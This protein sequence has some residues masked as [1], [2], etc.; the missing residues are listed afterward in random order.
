MDETTSQDVRASAQQAIETLPENS[1]WEDV[2]YRI[3]V[4]QKIEEGLADAEAERFV[5]ETDLRQQLGSFPNTNEK[6]FARC[7]YTRTA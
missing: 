3:Y 1:T 4:R 2:I 7:S 6:T 5:D